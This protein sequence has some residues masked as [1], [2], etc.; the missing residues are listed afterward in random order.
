M[1]A[2]E[3]RIGNYLYD[4]G[5]HI[6]K[7]ECIMSDRYVSWDDKESNLEFSYPSDDSNMYRPEPNELCPIHLSDEILTEWCGSRHTWSGNLHLFIIDNFTLQQFGAGYLFGERF[8]SIKYL[9]KL[10]NLYYAITGKELQ[11]KL[12]KQ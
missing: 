4:S 5:L 6:V 2:E 7:V 11:I 3:L 1:K 9:H 12:P 10:Q 8:D